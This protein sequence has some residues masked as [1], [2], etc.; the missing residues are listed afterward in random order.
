MFDFDVEI[1]KAPI[2]PFSG[3]GRAD[4]SGLRPHYVPQYAQQYVH[5][6]VQAMRALL[7]LLD[8]E[9][10]QLFGVCANDI[11]FHF[12]MQFITGKKYVLVV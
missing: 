8:Q 2:L 1:N 5:Q 6:L 10:S 3:D 4:P 9:C 12:F 7:A 11:K